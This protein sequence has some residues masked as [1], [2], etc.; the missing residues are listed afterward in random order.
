MSTLT[1]TNAILP[2][3]THTDLS[4]QVGGPVFLYEVNGV[5]KAAL[6]NAD[7]R[8]FGILLEAD[9]EKGSIG[10]LEGGLAGTVRVKVI[11]T[12]EV[13]SIL[14]ADRVDGET[15]FLDAATGTPSGKFVCAYALESGVAGERIEAVV[16]RPELQA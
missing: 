15:G 12:V 14:Y 7:Q 16:F 2:F 6:L 1:R 9:G 13:G 3:P 8:P 10:I 4:S 11:G 5:K